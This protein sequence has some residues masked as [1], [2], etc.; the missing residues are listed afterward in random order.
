MSRQILHSLFMK[1]TA[2]KP[3]GLTL[4]IISLFDI[5][6]DYIIYQHSSWSWWKVQNFVKKGG[7]LIPLIYMYITFFLYFP[8]IL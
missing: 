1:V 3:T 7:N 6:G 8:L 2:S 5:G 4:L